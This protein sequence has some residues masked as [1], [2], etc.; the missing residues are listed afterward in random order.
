MNRN[1]TATVTAELKEFC[2]FPEC[3][4]AIEL[5]TQGCYRYDDGTVFCVE[6]P[7]RQKEKGI[8]L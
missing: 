5:I 8:S 3:R 4:R 7:Q 1:G 6:H 2:C